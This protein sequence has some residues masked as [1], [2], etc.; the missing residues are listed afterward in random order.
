MTSLFC[1][2]V[3]TYKSSALSE[4]VHVEFTNLQNSQSGAL[5]EFQQTCDFNFVQNKGSIYSPDFPDPIPGELLPLDFC[6]WKLFSQDASLGA[7]IVEF[8][9][10]LT[11]YPIKLQQS[12]KTY[13]LGEGSLSISNYDVMITSA[14]TVATKMTSE[15][16]SDPFRI[17][18]RFI[19]IQ[20]IK[21]YPSVNDLNFG[22]KVT[23]FSSDESSSSFYVHWSFTEPTSFSQQ[24]VVRYLMDNVDGSID[25]ELPNMA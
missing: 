11:I 4:P 6:S 21:T 13:T 24:Q 15:T 19:S 5:V 25:F 18:Y 2:E 16:V 1:I 8:V 10:F 7:L 20:N 23:Q 14:F 22:D 3:S 9:G 17:N 12:S